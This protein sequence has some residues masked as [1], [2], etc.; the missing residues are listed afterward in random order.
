MMKHAKKTLQ[1]GD[2]IYQLF[3]Y[4]EVIIQGN[5]E[6]FIIRVE[7][8]AVSKKNHEPYYPQRAMG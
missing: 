8:I 4:Q 2:K 1:P 3:N 5:T 6:N 7:K